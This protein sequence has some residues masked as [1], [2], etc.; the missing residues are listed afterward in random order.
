MGL[1]PR[2][3]LFWLLF[4]AAVVTGLAA[5]YFGGTLIAGLETRGERIHFVYLG[6]LLVF[7]LA[8]AGMR[9][10]SRPATHLRHALV[11]ASVALVLVIAYSFRYELVA[12]AQR[13]K[14]E[15]LP[16]S[17]VESA[18]G[19]VAFRAD[20]S[21]HFRVTAEVEG[22]PIRFLVDTG[23]SLVVLSPQD[24]ARIGRDPA[25]LVYGQTFRTANGA[26]RGAAIR[27]DELRIGGIALRD[28]HASVNRAPMSDSLLGMS[29]LTRLSG[30][31]VEGG[32]LTLVR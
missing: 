27:L 3:R 22:T 10:R 25:G 13:V 12:L 11:W 20:R 24:A 7:L 9:W 17:G 4:A 2:R 32:V 19:R 26:G 8:S 28:V 31:S 21:G 23:A 14:G 16:S 5:A 1:R 29:F 15:L 6:L 18:P 30:Y